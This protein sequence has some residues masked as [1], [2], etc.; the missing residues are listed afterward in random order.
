MTFDLLLLPVHKFGAEMLPSNKM[1]VSQET[2]ITAK[3][4][5][6]LVPTHVKIAVIYYSP[7]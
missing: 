2:T 4:Y 6:T 3:N 5:L 1:T 7:S